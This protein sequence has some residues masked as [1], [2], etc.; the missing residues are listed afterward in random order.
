[1]RLL[2]VEDNLEV[3]NSMK[4][5]LEK[6]GFYVDI[7]DNA[8]E[9]EEKAY[10]NEYDLL[11][12][13]LKLPDKSGSDIVKYL[14][15]ENVDVPV[16]I[17]SGCSD[18]FEIINSFN[19]GVD[20]Y[21][22]KPFQIEELIARIQAVI[23]RVN[24]KVNPEIVIGNFKINTV[25][26]K[27][28]YNNKNIDLTSKEYDILE[29][30]ALKYPAIISSEELLEHVYDENFDSLSSVLRVHITKVRKKI[31]KISG[32]DILINV[33]GKGYSLYNG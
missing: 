11:L 5:E 31:K 6:H 12:I 32:I 26:R 3:L 1:M 14:R 17:I 21:I 8:I 20:D 27:A 16:I 29:Y 30:L 28:T 13:D 10:I 23:R 7:A 25:I 19:L 22:K 2:I 33:R 24:G 15:S 4:I 18:N 9:G